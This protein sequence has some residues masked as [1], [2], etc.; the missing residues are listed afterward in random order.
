MSLQEAAIAANRFGLGARPG[1]LKTISGDPRGWLKAQLTA[2]TALPAPLAALPS[3]RDDVT[4]F[5]RWIVASGLIRSVG[6]Y[7]DGKIGQDAAAMAAHADTADHPAM[8]GDAPAPNTA[9]TVADFTS[10]RVI[11]VGDPDFSVEKSFIAWFGP[12][13]VQAVSARMEVATT[14]DRP[15]FER[16]VR[17]WGNHFTVSSAKP[18]TQAMPPSFERDVARRHAVDRFGAMLRA[19][20][21]HP[22]MLVYLDNYVSVGPDA[23]LVKH[24]GFLP[25]A[26]RAQLKGLNENLAR[27][28]LELHTLGVRSGYTQG[29]VTTFAKIITGWTIKARGEGQGETGLFNFVPGLHEPGPQTILGVTFDQG[30]VDQGEA[31]LDML[32]RRPETARFIATKLVRHFVADDPPPA[33][34]DRIAAVFRDTDGDLRA[35]SAALVDL[36]EAWS[37][38][39]AKVRPPEDY[40]VATVRALGGPKLNGVQLT[41]LFSRMGQRPYYA[42]GPNGWSDVGAD[43]IGPDPL[44]KRLEFASAVGAGMANAGAS[45]I[46]VAEACLGPSLTSQTREAIAK[47]ESPAQGL[48]LLLVSPE[49]QRR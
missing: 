40:V 8:A 13:Y 17:F 44:W 35:V 15:F 9:P 43:W 28:I 26:F 4:A 33:A 16:L 48:A 11:K 7:R 12:R 39:P 30:G 47:A 31:A 42:A 24:P 3:T 27:E 38:A 25:A 10:G 46:T 6:Q 19:S 18:A 32:A 36:P 14:T 22:G 2:E 23:F 1:D 49:F 34:V 37:P 5:Q 41:A 21:Q 29:D 20:T 45:P